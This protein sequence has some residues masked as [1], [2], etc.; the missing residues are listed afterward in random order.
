M[1][2]T[3]Y[4]K[5]RRMKLNNAWQLSEMN[6]FVIR[7]AIVS[8]LSIAV[9][10]ALSFVHFYFEEKE[11]HKVTMLE[12]ER[13]EHVILSCLNHGGMGINGELHLCR[14]ANTWVKL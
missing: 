6:A 1:S 10:A 3:L 9:L 11:A 12:T 8:A 13:L 7:L 2:I 4:S 14:P 5:Y